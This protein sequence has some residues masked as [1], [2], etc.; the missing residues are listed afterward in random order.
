MWEGCGDQ[1]IQRALR[2]LRVGTWS[3]FF[4]VM[5]LH[6]PLHLLWVLLLAGGQAIQRGGTR[7]LGALLLRSLFE[8]LIGYIL[9]CCC[10]LPAVCLASDALVGGR[11][12]SALACGVGRES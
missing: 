12:G 2:L 10:A 3:M 9:N 4:C 1:P 6:A 11:A 7:A 8:S 5:S